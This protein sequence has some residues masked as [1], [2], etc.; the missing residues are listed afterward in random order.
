MGTSIWTELFNFLVTNFFTFT[1][2]IGILVIPTTKF[3]KKDHEDIVVKITVALVMLIAVLDRQDQ[4]YETA[5]NVPVFGRTVVSVINYILRP[6]AIMLLG[7]AIA[8][9]FMKKVWIY[10]PLAIVIAIHT[11]SFY[12]DICVSFNEQNGFVRGPLGLTSAIITMAYL[13]IDIAIILWEHRGKAYEEMIPLFFVAAIGTIAG[14]LELVGVRNLLNG[15]IVIG[16]LFYHIFIFRMR[17]KADLLTDLYNRQQ[18][19]SDIVKNR[20]N[21]KT[22]I[23]IDMNGLKKL[24]DTKGHAA[25]DKALMT[26]GKVLKKNISYKERAYRIGGDEFIVLSKS[27]EPAYISQWIN[28]VEG[29]LFDGGIACSFGYVTVSEYDDIENAIQN[30]DEMM[31]RDKQE[32]YSMQKN[33]KI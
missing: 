23:S 4:Y 15:G 11:T 28:K 20:K 3:A 27:N 12:S 33:E 29:D 10:V 18:L 13:A 7:L 24:N 2:G 17:T 5:Y 21:I 14:V 30:A 26:I 6:G 1:L 9:S 16:C 22:I 8:P 19:Y 32:Y 25:G 31:Y